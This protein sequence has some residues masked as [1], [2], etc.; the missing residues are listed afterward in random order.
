MITPLSTMIRH[1][2]MMTL[3]S[4]EIN[5]PNRHDDSHDM[6]DDNHD[7]NFNSQYSNNE[8]HPLY[9]DNHEE[10]DDRQFFV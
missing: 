2:C 4:S 3:H 1:F 6:N 9:Y 5:G 8:N 7:M 10:Y